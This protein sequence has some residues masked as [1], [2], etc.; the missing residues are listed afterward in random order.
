MSLPSSEDFHIPSTKSA[1]LAPLSLVAK[2][3][4]EISFIFTYTKKNRRKYTY[5]HHHIPKFKEWFDIET[6]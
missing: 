4:S 3:S 5:L 2:P 6:S 1:K